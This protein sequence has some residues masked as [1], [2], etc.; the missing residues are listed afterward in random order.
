MISYKDLC[1][2]ALQHLHVTYNHWPQWLL[3]YLNMQVYQSKCGYTFDLDKPELFTEKIQWYK[4]R[5][6]HP[7][8]GRYVDKV[9]F[10]G[11]IEEKLGLGHTIPMY[12]NW[13]SVEDFRSAWNSLPEKFCL[14]SNLSS[15]GNFIKVIERSKTDL[16]SL[17]RELVEWLKPKN[18]LINSFCRGYHNA[19]PKILAEKY[20][21]NVK[22]QL[23][24]Y[25]FYC[26]GGLPH[27]VCASINHFQDEH[28][29]ISYFDLDWN[30]MPV[31]SGVHKSE[32]IPKPKHFEE[33]IELA[34]KL[35]EGFP[36][37]RVD[38]FDTDEKLYMAELTFYP[39][40]GFFKY[41]PASF[42]KEM[43]DLFILPIK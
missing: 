4:F 2:V 42:N 39:G 31:K 33:M 32:F 26:F 3:E 8:M 5:Y 23:Y 17:C 34:K 30:L 18:L 41:D 22:D 10:K 12:G 16:D 38:F 13:T 21:E 11:L 29:P 36:F 1:C 40:G 43:G 27:C 28:Y 9:L 7:E 14:K 25:K 15:E 6:M 19:T 37:L 20:E 35:S 24:D